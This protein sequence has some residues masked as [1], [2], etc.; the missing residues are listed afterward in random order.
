MYRCSK[1]CDTRTAAGG[2]QQRG[3]LMLS[4]PQT[5]V[6]N[7]TLKCFQR[8]FGSQSKYRWIVSLVPVDVVRCI[9]KIYGSYK[10]LISMLHHLL[11]L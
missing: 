4:E 5:R 11:L 7:A 2:W 3:R 10:Y 8:N 9:N 6:H 1:S